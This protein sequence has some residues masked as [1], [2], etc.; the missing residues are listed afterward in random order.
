MVLAALS[1]HTH[2]RKAFGDKAGDVLVDAT[3]GVERT[4][5][6][7]QAT[8]FHVLAIKETP[9]AEGV[10]GSNPTTLRDLLPLSPS[11]CNHS[12]IHFLPAYIPIRLPHPFPYSKSGGRE[13]SERSVRHSY[14]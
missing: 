10:L 5:A 3:K 1:V 14:I 9:V 8:G 13:R 2:I 11:P 4:I 7:I 12:Y 6:A